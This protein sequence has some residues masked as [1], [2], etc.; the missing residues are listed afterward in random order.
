MISRS[1]KDGKIFTGKFAELA[2]RVGFA[3]PVEEE[4]K[5]A[6]AKKKPVAKKTTK[7]KK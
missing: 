4:K 2:V 7:K 1:K 3:E 5:K 6:P